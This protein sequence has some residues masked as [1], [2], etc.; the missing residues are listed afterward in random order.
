[1]KKVK[2]KKTFKKYKNTKWLLRHLNDEYYLQSKKKGYRSRSVYKLMQINHKFR[3][4]SDCSTVLDLGAAPG[5]WCQVS[6][7]ILGKESKILGID[8][9]PIKS[10]EGVKFIVCD[11]TDINVENEIEN[12]FEKK[13]DVILSDI[14]PNTTGNKS[15]DHLK[16]I[17]LIEVVLVIVKKFLKKEGYFVCKIFQGGAQGDL[18]KN[19]REILKNMKYFKP[20]A[21]RK[22]S[23]ETYLIAQKK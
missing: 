19:M 10:F 13:I 8:I 16:I 20:P 22:E 17:S 1:M 18:N 12:F 9:N 11:I 21:S 3:I 6:K 5:G 15:A 7:N 4:F 14:A 23:P 2:L